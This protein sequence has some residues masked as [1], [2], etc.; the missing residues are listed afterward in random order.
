MGKNIAGGR[1]GGLGIDRCIINII[2]GGMILAG[3]LV[4]AAHSYYLPRLDIYINQVQ[5]NTALKYAGAYTLMDQ[6]CTALL[7]DNQTALA[8]LTAGADAQSREFRLNYNEKE[9]L[10]YAINNSTPQLPIIPTTISA[11][12]GTIIGRFAIFTIASQ[13]IMRADGCKYRL[14]TLIVPDQSGNWQIKT[15]RWVRIDNDWSVVNNI[16]ADQSTQIFWDYLQTIESDKSYDRLEITRQLSN[17]NEGIN[18]KV[19]PEPLPTAYPGTFSFKAGSSC[20]D[21]DGIKTIIELLKIDAVAES[22][23][24]INYI[25]TLLARSCNWDKVE[26]DEIYTNYTFAAIVPRSVTRK[27]GLELVPG[28]FF[29]AG[30]N[31]SWQLADYCWLEE[32]DQRAFIEG[33]ITNYPNIDTLPGHGI[34]MGRLP[35]TINYGDLLGSW[36]MIEMTGPG[37]EVLKKT[38]LNF[39]NQ[40][41]IFVE[42]YTETSF[43]TNV[44]NYKL[45]NNQLE[46]VVDGLDGKM[47]GFMEKGTLEIIDPT[48][49]RKLILQKEGRIATLPDNMMGTWQ[50]TESSGRNT[51]NLLNCVFNFK[52]GNQL[53]VDLYHSTGTNSYI[54]KFNIKDKLI[55]IRQQDNTQLFTGFLDGDDMTLVAPN[56]KIKMHKTDSGLVIPEY[57]LGKWQTTNFVGDN[58]SGYQWASLNFKANNIAIIESIQKDEYYTSEANYSFN[59]ANGRIKLFNNSG[60]TYTLYIE[61]GI[62]ELFF[63]EQNLKLIFEKGYSMPAQPLQN[64]EP[65]SQEDITITQ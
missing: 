42:S 30:P 14:R 59:P 28:L 58:T 51:D 24:D 12:N 50:M 46:I 16:R 63:S 33:F 32:K 11:S 1:R 23:L 34:A 15:A 22:N 57:L 13:P 6:Y 20:I 54:C 40:T 10:R 41:L 49:N 27:D 19:G 48:L 47:T 45:V 62:I 25:I 64:N 53:L 38:T 21:T 29:L 26:I 55:T 17:I 2:L 60:E 65:P 44:W 39:K 7:T 43:E 31:N 35:A 5:E 18:E 37:S 3:S 61:N 36:Q 9:K 4:S 8:L 52:A 56:I